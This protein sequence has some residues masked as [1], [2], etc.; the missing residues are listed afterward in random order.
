M[1]TVV[2]YKPT[3]RGQFEA[4][5]TLSIMRTSFNKKDFKLA[6]L[7]SV[8]EGKSVFM[9]Y[10]IVTTRLFSPH[11]QDVLDAFI[12]AI[13]CTRYVLQTRKY[14]KGVSARAR[15]RK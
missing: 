11:E 14:V 9:H 7:E 15:R 1:N 8:Q 6:M 3:P 2:K 12:R 13:E 10:A 5:E 4:K